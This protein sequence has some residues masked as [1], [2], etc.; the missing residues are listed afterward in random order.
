MKIVLF[1]NKNAT[2]MRAKEV[3]MDLAKAYENLNSKIP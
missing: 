3:S 2:I 1:F